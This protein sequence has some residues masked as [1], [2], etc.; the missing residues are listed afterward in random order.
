MESF[1]GEHTDAVNT[2]LGK[3]GMRV[4]ERGGSSSSVPLWSV[5]LD[6]VKD[7]VTLEAHEFNVSADNEPIGEVLSWEVFNGNFFI[8]QI[9]I[10]SPFMYTFNGK[11]PVTVSP[12]TIDSHGVDEY[13]ANILPALMV[14]QLIPAIQNIPGNTVNSHVL[15]EGSGFLARQRLCARGDDLSDMDLLIKSSEIAISMARSSALKK[16]LKDRQSGFMDGKSVDRVCIWFRAP[17]GPKRFVLLVMEMTSAKSGCFIVDSHDD[18]T[19]HVC[20]VSQFISFINTDGY[21]IGPKVTALNN[22]VQDSEKDFMGRLS[23]IV[24]NTVF[25]SLTGSFSDA[26]ITTYNDA[27]RS[28]ITY[29]PDDGNSFATKLCNFLDICSRDSKIVWLSPTDFEFLNIRDVY[30]IPVHYSTASEASVLPSPDDLVF[31]Q[32]L[33]IPKP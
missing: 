29:K 30:L 13:Y 12:L 25:F 18:K 21:L 28:E 32:G 26:S 11:F 7:Q 4:C 8:E 1:L 33:S 17:R 6:Y 14:N 27:F 9:N 2:V 20:I 10:V 19:L 5:S 3:W 23:F 16:I 24:R 15:C 31:H 22:L